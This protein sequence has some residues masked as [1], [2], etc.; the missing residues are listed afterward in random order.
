M[1]HLDR[2]ATISGVL[3]SLIR[4][5]QDVDE[6]KSWL[7]DPTNAKKKVKYKTFYHGLMDRVRAEDISNEMLLLLLKN[8]DR[9]IK[10]ETFFWSIGFDPR[11]HFNR[12]LSVEQAKLI[13][14]HHD[15]IFRD[16]WDEQSQFLIDVY[17][18]TLEVEFIDHIL[19]HHRV[20]WVRLIDSRNAT[21]ESIRTFL[22]SG[23]MPIEE[24]RKR[25]GLFESKMAS[26]YDQNQSSFYGAR[27]M[28]IFEYLRD[29]C[30][31]HIPKVDPNRAIEEYHRRERHRDLLWG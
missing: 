7:D 23:K 31:E 26:T 4:S 3:E 27:R 8:D 15:D 21:I 19:E 22:E 20:S 29:F 30:A 25:V 2:D 24:L 14:E 18:N 10:R 5:S 16:D 11:N 1:S 28:K 9:I 6:M 17:E 12:A 13:W